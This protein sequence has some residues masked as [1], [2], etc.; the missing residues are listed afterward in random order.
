MEKRYNYT[1]I[2][3]FQET[4]ESLRKFIGKHGFRTPDEFVSAAISYFE[5]TGDDPREPKITAKTAI[6]KNNERLSQV[7]AFIR[8]F[9]RRHMKPLLKDV[10][11]TNIE[12]RQAVEQLPNVAKYISD[13]LGVVGKNGIVATTVYDELEEI[14][15]F[16]K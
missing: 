11:Q 5:T 1:T 12:I 6:E 4:R 14:K 7:I 9:E 13:Q 15:S 10:E 8:E 16:L 2:S 3:V